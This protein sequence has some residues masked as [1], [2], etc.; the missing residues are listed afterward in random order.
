MLV[1]G[2]AVNLNAQQENCVSLARHL[3][4]NPGALG[5]VSGYA[6][7]G[8]T[9]ALRAV[10]DEVEERAC[11]IT[12][13]GRAALRVREQTG[14]RANTIHSLLYVP[15]EDPDTAVVRFHRRSWQDLEET[16]PELLIVDEAS[17]VGRD[18][19]G[20][21]SEI[22]DRLHRSVL[23][24]GDGAQLPP[25][26]LDR[27][28]EPFSVFAPDFEV[29]A[30]RVELTEVFRQALDSPVLAAATA[31]RMAAAWWEVERVL[32]HGPLQWLKEPIHNAAARDVTA[33][34]DSAVITHRNATRLGL[35]HWIRA[36]LGRPTGTP[37]VEGEPLLV[38]R[39]SSEL[40]VCNGE[41]IPYQPANLPP[42]KVGREWE[43]EQVRTPSG[44]AGALHPST[45][46]SGQDQTIPRWVPAKLEEDRL[47]PFLR[48][49]LGYALTCHSAQGSEWATVYVVV[50]G[51]LSV[52]PEDERRRWI[53]TAITRSSG[54]CW[55]VRG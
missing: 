28:A 46:L 48:A 5:V 10:L 34:A 1:R 51:S 2:S 23:L 8:K 12:P 35:N 38:R 36:A 52:M 9:T 43:F 55:L 30:P 25:V 42:L 19:W 21:L 16:L 27:E 22:R 31:V 4:S 26:Q 32:F 29:E 40:G 47:T 6:G 45:V 18:V 37:L 11:V 50:E 7:T 49:H 13:T 17:M 41:V 15:E 24:V 33:K 20:D 54:A 39:N 53:Y 44:A 14:Y 3:V